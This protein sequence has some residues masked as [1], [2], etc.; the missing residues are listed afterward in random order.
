MQAGC[1][2][3]GFSPA[4]ADSCKRLMNSRGHVSQQHESYRK[5]CT[6]LGMKSHEAKCNSSLP[7]MLFRVWGEILRIILELALQ[8]GLL[9]QQSLHL[10][11]ALPS[12]MF[13]P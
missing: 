8:L 6:K 1:K 3:S 5:P 12:H 13:L 2:R 4:C 9:W 11:R 7:G 10:H